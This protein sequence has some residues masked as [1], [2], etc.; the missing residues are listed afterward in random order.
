MNAHRKWAAAYKTGSLIVLQAC[1]G[2]Y[3]VA[4]DL[5]VEPLILPAGAVT[6]EELGHATR[7]ALD[8]SRQMHSAELD[9]FLDPQKLQD[10]YELW[11]AAL[12]KLGSFPDRLA[13]FAD[14]R[15]CPIVDDGFEVAIQPTVHERPEAWS[16]LDVEF[17]IRTPNNA[18][19]AEL[20]FAVRSALEQSR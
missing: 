20:G 6:C 5:Q 11:V 18:S 12:V 17:Q 1:S 15:H 7:R 16:R 9:A 2:N 19:D 4:I 8:A 13:L 14:M 10:R 3:R